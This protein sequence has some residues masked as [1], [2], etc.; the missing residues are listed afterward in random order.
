M[1]RHLRTD[2]MLAALDMALA[3]RCPA[4]GVIHHPGQG[5]HYTS[6][7][8]GERCR[9]AGVRPSLGRVGACYDNALAELFFATLECELLV[10]GLD[11]PPRLPQRGL[12]PSARRPASPAGGCSGGRSQT[13]RRA[14]TLAGAAPIMNP[15]RNRDTSTMM[16]RRVVAAR[17]NRHVVSLSLGLLL[18][19]V[20]L[21]CEDGPNEPEPPPSVG[22]LAFSAESRLLPTE[23][24]SVTRFSLS[25]V[26]R[27]IGS[28][29][30]ETGSG[31][32]R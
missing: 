6:I 16:A 24:D 31:T 28:G 18:L 11:C 32:V 27:N 13:R 1:E 9:R 15:P 21:A 29:P 30:V 5:W 26:A 4:A 22:E 19:G 10:R 14:W 12:A 3:R 2:L 20:C 23:A 17:R 8:F 25:V 7:A